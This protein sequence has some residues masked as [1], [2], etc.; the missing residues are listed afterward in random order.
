MWSDAQHEKEGLETASWINQ[1]VSS[2]LEK[3]RQNQELIK[4]S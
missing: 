4:L 3:M 1:L 2:G